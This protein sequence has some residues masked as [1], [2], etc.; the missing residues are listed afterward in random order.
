MTPSPK[1]VGGVVCPDYSFG[2]VHKNKRF[3]KIIN[4]MHGLLQWRPSSCIISVKHTYLGRFSVLLV[5][6]K[7]FENKKLSNIFRNNI[8]VWLILIFFT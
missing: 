3:E 1:R 5:F 2:Q 8:Q 4:V 6:I 7:N